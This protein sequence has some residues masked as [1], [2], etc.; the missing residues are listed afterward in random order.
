MNQPVV[1]AVPLR[2]APP[3]HLRHRPIECSLGA[4][5]VLGH[6][7]LDHE[8]LTAETQHHVRPAAGGGLLHPQ[9]RADR[10]QAHIEEACIPHLVACK[11]A[12]RMP[13]VGN[14]RQPG[15]QPRVEAREVVRCQ[16]CAELP[17]LLPRIGA[18]LAQP[19]QQ[20]PVQADPNL[21]IGIVEAIESVEVILLVLRD[22]KLLGDG[23][24]A[25]LE[26]QR[27]DADVADVEL[28]D[29]RR[30]RQPALQMP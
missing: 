16:Q 4:I 18:R 23:E 27:L 28:R 9:V 7:E 1:V 30:V 14:P 11:I 15:P 22:G 2:I 8:D 26:E 12:S 24:I 20:A 19:G 25:S 6:L 3:A 10:A 21:T 13:L 29:Q 5:R 17:T